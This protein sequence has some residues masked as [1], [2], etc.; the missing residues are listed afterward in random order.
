MNRTFFFYFSLVITCSFLSACGSKTTE[1]VYNNGVPGT[2]IA[3]VTLWDSLSA[4]PGFSPV[5]DPSGVEVSIEGTAFKALT[6]KNGDCTIQNVPPG[7]YNFLFKKTGFSTQVI[8]QKAFPGNGTDVISTVLYLATHKTVE[9]ITRPFD[10]GTA[11]LSWKIL[12]SVKSDERVIGHFF[13]SDKPG[14]S[15]YD[16]SSYRYVVYADYTES[17]NNVFIDRG[18]LLS[19]GFS[20]N[21]TIYCLL[22]PSGINFGYYDPISE[23]RIFYDGLS[24][25]NSGEKSVFL[26]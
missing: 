6:D 17:T 7:V 22:V 9:L 18:S 8:G 1:I 4:F 14:I 3:R 2:I 16:T 26:P 25:Y 21:Q 11:T 10:A 19:S 24:P 15:P 13:F 23:K 20:G 12:D 5:L